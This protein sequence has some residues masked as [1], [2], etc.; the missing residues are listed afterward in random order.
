MSR[1]NPTLAD[2][3]RG[4]LDSRLGDL[5]VAIPAR[6]ESYNADRQ[7]C[8]AQPLVRVAVPEA[9]VEDDSRAV[10]RLPVINGVPVVFPGAG[11]YSITWPLAKGDI[12]LLVFSEAALDKWKTRGDDV[13]PGDD[14]R[15]ALSDAIAI[16]GLRAFGGKGSAAPVSGAGGSGSAPDALV[17]QA[18]EIRAGGT[19]ALALASELNALRTA[20]NAHVHT[21][22]T[23][24]GGSSGTT[25]SAVATPYDGTAVLKGG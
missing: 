13:D 6:V 4:A 17:I 9:Q 24:G 3:L 14:R 2:V 8:S 12:V 22:V 19:D 11:D 7:S 1:N 16:P 18:P 15:H 21:G 25:P 23:T 20:F 10:E 5:H